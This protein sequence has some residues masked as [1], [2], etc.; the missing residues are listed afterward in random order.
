VLPQSFNPTQVPSLY[1]YV[2]EALNPHLKKFL[3]HFFSTAQVDSPPI[4]FAPCCFPIFIEGL[5]TKVIGPNQIPLFQFGREQSIHE[6]SI[7]PIKV[8][9][10]AKPY[11]K[12]FQKA[13]PLTVIQYIGSQ[14]GYFAQLELNKIIDVDILDT[15]NACRHISELSCSQRSNYLSFLFAHHP[16]HQ[17]TKGSIDIL[18]P[19]D[20][21]FQYLHFSV[22]S[23]QDVLA[24]FK[25][26]R[27]SLNVYTI[28]RLLSSRRKLL[29]AWWD[30]I[31]DHYERKNFIALAQEAKIVIPLKWLRNHKNRE[32]ICDVLKGY[33]TLSKH[34]R[35]LQFMA[36][37]W[38]S[39]Q[40]DLG[41]LFPENAPER[42]IIKR[43]A[44][45]SA[46]IK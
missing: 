33:S 7:E 39:K 14:S 25:A 15:V 22:F 45:S 20:Y 44:A 19:R 9:L 5:A 32:L 23:D 12:H 24:A 41:C 28:K 3:L 38:A 31:T 2:N 30:S 13:F 21:P 27:H 16:D 26:Q 43:I 37:T 29:K 10:S 46:L 40:V 42:L 1:R 11:S 6:Q 17:L 18:D 4:I 8:I 34:P 35:Y 36:Y